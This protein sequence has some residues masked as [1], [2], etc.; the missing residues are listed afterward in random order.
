VMITGILVIFNAIPRGG[1]LQSLGGLVEGAWELSLSF[2]CIVK[3]FRA[4][5]PI[6]STDGVTRLHES[7]SA[8][9]Q[10]R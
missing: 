4:S 6:F 8:L 2:Y 3:G 7:G 1:A 5:S 10:G 9:R